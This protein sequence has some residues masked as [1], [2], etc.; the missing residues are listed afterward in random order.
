M[1]FL[2]FLLTL[3]HVSWCFG[4]I[5]L[6]DE[7]GQFRSPA[8][9][10]E[11]Y[12][13]NQD[14]TWEITADPGYQVVVYFSIFD[15]EDSY[16]EEMGGSCA[17]DFLEIEDFGVRKK[18]CGNYQTYPYDAPHRQQ[19]FRSKG[20]IMRVRFVSDYSNEGQIWGF[21]AHYVIEDADECAQM[22][23][24][25]RHAFEDWDE[26]IYCNHY[27]INVPG[28][29]YCTCRPGFQLHENHHTCRASCEN[30]VLTEESGIITSPDYPAPYSRLTDCDWTIQVRAG[31]SLNIMFEP[32]FDIELHPDYSDCPY[33]YLKVTI[34]EEEQKF[35]GTEVPF[36]GDF[37]PT[38][39]R[40]V[41]LDFH[42]DN[43]VE[44]AGFKITYNTTR[45]KCLETRTAPLNGFITNEKLSGIYE[46]EDEIR[47]SCNPGYKLVGE[48]IITC[49]NN[50]VWNHDNPVC[51]IKSCGA[52]GHLTNVP[53]AHIVDFDTKRFTYAEQLSIE[54]NNWY[55]LVSG[56]TEWICNADANWVP[57][58]ETGENNIPVCK[59]ICGRK[60]G[61]DRT[62]VGQ[63]I[64]GGTLAAKNEWPWVAFINFARNPNV[65][66]NFFTCGGFLISPQ[67]ILTAAHCITRSHVEYP[68][69][70]L[71][72]TNLTHVWLGAHDRRTDQEEYYKKQK[73]PEYNKK[74][75][76]RPVAI[77]N[78]IRHP[79][80]HHSS[81]DFDI[82][83]LR[84]AETVIMDDY[85]RPVCLPSLNEDF[86]LLNP[87]GSSGEVAGWGVHDAR[88]RP[89]VVLRQA[90]LPTVTNADCYASFQR[91]ARNLGVTLGSKVH[92][93]ENMFCAGFESGSR[94]STCQGDSGGAFMSQKN[95]TQKYYA[96]GLVSFGI[97]RGSCGLSVSYSGFT[98]ITHGFEQW[99]KENSDLE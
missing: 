57:E 14:I 91:K 60:N 63:H 20:N 54:C 62:L 29:Y 17:Y 82:A 35:C 81:W 2:L 7:Y 38:N 50:G 8:S 22:T 95:S 34:N 88:G 11:T 16:D 41:R 74:T 55:E 84:L 13:D 24:D 75:P 56:V 76:A 25:V 6:S 23:Y 26:M 3:S 68:P 58:T 30:Q 45:I 4:V 18:Y 15:L 28:S 92:L 96:L 80:Y 27:C 67:Y 71:I 10:G 43:A 40:E 46:F 66:T 79:S 44:K 97:A 93:T 9:L 73:D 64:S 12:L 70:G 86:D 36:S 99:I 48:S 51:E 33:D 78:I 49:Q 39:A 98:R 53:Y 83:L 69:D 19:R 5:R 42:T 94:S 72:W 87:G 32:V 89:S 37:Y 1:R 85:V 59:P 61:A 21:R 47:F 65:A 52:P 90:E 31:M 77:S